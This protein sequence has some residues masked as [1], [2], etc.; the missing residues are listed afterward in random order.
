LPIA[1]KNKRSWPACIYIA[2][3]VKTA[4]G[5]ICTRAR[6]TVGCF[7]AKTLLVSETRRGDRA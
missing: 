1:P 3:Y 5:L 4:R 7:L 2:W 6:A